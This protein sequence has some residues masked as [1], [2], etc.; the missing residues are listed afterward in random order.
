VPHTKKFRLKPSFFAS[1]TDSDVYSSSSVCV[2]RDM[3]ETI[4]SLRVRDM[5]LEDVDGVVEVHRHCF[6]ASVSIF[7]VLNR[8]V[9]KSYYAQFVHEPE[10]LGAVLEEPE[11]GRIVG[12]AVGTIRPGFNRRFVQRHFFKFGWHILKG[13]FISATI[14]RVVGAHFSKIGR[15]FPGKRNGA[16]GNSDLP[17]AKGQVGIFMPIAVHTQWRSGGNAAKLATYFAD[18]FFKRGVARVQGR[19][20]PD[21]L[22]CLKLFRKLGWSEKKVSG[23]WI[24]VWIDRAEGNS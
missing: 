19:I 20:A 24:A 8:D 6:P 11:S 10:S 4:S 1:R 18:Q 14:R 23:E 17:P 2:R 5:T 7:S 16:P 15:V 12:F 21:N 22:P 9:V 13:L 3:P